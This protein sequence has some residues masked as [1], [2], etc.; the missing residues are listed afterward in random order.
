VR[1]LRTGIAAARRS[2]LIGLGAVVVAGAL[3][4]TGVLLAT[5][6]GPG[7]PLTPQSSTRAVALGDSVPYGHGLANPYRTPRPG[8]P[9]RDASQGPSAQAYPSLVARTL[10]LSMTVRTANCDLHGDQ[11]AISGAVADPADDTARDTQCPVP[12]QPTRSLSTELARAD[13]AQH[14]ARLVLL[15]AGADD[16][17]FGTCLEYQLG[18]VLGVGIG[19]GTQCVVNGTVTAAVA[20]RLAHAR[21]S[22]TDAI[23]SVAPHAGTIAVLNYY[24]PVPPPSEIADDSGLSGLGVN[25]VC[26]GIRANAAATYAAALVVSGAVNHA[27]AGAVSDARARG[28]HN[29]QLIDVSAVGAGHGMCTSDPWFFSGE[30]LS[31]AT[32]TGDVARIAAGKACAATGALGRTSPC[33]G[34][35]VRAAQAKDELAAHVWRA[36]HPTAVGQ[37]ALAT[38][39]EAQLRAASSRGGSASVDGVP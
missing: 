1:R 20:T 18:R 33:T 31:D 4:A 11:L 36:A 30:E 35:Q 10:D 22:L 9:A 14:P 7:P 5:R 27:V 13:L 2:P 38:A 16:I 26:T 25:L 19:L 24:Q 34:L 3:T 15:Q 12:P 37:R 21:T 8:L 17:D 23:E 28:V 39:V 32:L 29:V 6:P